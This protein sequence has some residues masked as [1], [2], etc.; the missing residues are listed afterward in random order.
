MMR[1]WARL[2]V[3]KIHGLILHWLWARMQRT[4][5][6]SHAFRDQLD[7]VISRLEINENH[8]PVDTKAALNLARQMRSKL[9]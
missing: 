9:S 7:Q 8:A 6:D 1:S 2:K 4:V 3:W 5:W